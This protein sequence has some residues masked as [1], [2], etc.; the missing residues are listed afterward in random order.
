MPSLAVSNDK[1]KVA[2]PI[3]DLDGDEMT[4]W[5]P[6]A[7]SLRRQGDGGREVLRSLPKLGPAAL[8]KHI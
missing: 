1:I 4:R 3:V 6:P 5:V 7:A 8:G 2:N